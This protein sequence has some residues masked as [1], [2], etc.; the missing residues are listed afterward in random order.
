MT[1]GWGIFFLV[2][3]ALLALLAGTF[4]VAYFAAGLSWLTG[5]YILISILNRR[6]NDRRPRHRRH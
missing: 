2:Y 6:S 4:P 3:A 1:V 5:S